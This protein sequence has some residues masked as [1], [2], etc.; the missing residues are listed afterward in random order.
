MLDNILQKSKNAHCIKFSQFQFFAI[1]DSGVYTQHIQLH[2]LMSADH[3][4]KYTKIYPPQKIAMATSVVHKLTCV[5][6]GRSLQHWLYKPV[7]KPRMQL[8]K[9][10][11]AAYRT[12]SANA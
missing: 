1:C 7:A 2:L 4:A 9:F 12:C 10:Y 3:L 8:T 6:H 11:F 5:V